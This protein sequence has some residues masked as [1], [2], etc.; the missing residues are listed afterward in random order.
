MNSQGLQRPF[1][2]LT[3]QEQLEMVNTTGTY[4]TY[5]IYFSNKVSLYSL[6]KNF[7]ETWFDYKADK[8]TKVSAIELESVQKIYCSAYKIR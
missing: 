4:L 2:D 8:V 5:R 1:N 7:V 6:G 3:I